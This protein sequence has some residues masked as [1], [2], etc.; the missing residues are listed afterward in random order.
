MM[1]LKEFDQLKRFMMLA[2]SDNDH[3]ALASLHAANALLKKHGLTWDAVFARLVRVGVEIEAAPFEDD[4]RQRIVEAFEVALR[5]A[6]GSFRRFLQDMQEQFDRSG[7]LSI[8][9]AN[10]LFRSARRA[11]WQG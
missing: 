7:S 11:G 1:T 6:T 9:Q 5:E 2:T 8:N 3:E 10:A 4:E